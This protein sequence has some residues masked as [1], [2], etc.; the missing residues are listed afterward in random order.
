MSPYVPNVTFDGNT[1]ARRNAANLSPNVTPM[2]QC[3]P[4]VIQCAPKVTFDGN[5]LG[6]R[7]TLELPMCSECPLKGHIQSDMFKVFFKTTLKISPDVI[8]MISPMSSQ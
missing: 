1:F 6:R 7:E 5:T 8:P 2:S 3:V 4:N